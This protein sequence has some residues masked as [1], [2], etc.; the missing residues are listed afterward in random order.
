MP[1]NFLIRRAAAVVNDGGVIAY[2][3]E[4]VYGLGC[5]PDDPDAVAR[6]LEIKQR[7]PE[8]GL[9][10][11]AAR[12]DQLE[13]YFAPLSKAS[14]HKLDQAWPGPQ[15]WLVPAAD[16][17]PDWLTGRHTTIAAR[18][19]AH[20]IASALCD[21]CGHALV[22]TS[23]NLS[24]RPPARDNRS[25]RRMLGDEVDYILGGPVGRLGKATPVRDLL[26]GKV[27]RP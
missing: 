6:L 2:P 4:G 13:D 27:L 14:R 24:G 3:T 5:D 15:T 26:T 23:A 11:I 7:S 16:D 20:P 8:Q 21:Q 1:S 25:V 18:V 10:V 12:I 17:A 9:I 19:T 22:S